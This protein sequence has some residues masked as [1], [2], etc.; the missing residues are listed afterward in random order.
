MSED[1]LTVQ[2][3]EPATCLDVPAL[4][5]TGKVDKSSGRQQG[6]FNTLS[7]SNVSST[8]TW[9]SAI[10]RQT[11]AALEQLQ[12]QWRT[13]P[14]FMPHSW[15]PGTSAVALPLSAIPLLKRQGT[16]PETL[17]RTAWPSKC[18]GHGLAELEWG[19][20][21]PRALHGA[22][23]R[24]LRSF[25][26]GRLCAEAALNRL[27]SS[28]TVIPGFCI[29][30]GVAEGIDMGPH[31][32]PVWPEVN[33]HCLTGSITHSERWAA[34]VVCPKAVIQSIGI[35]CE[36][37]MDGQS[38]DAALE[39]CFTKW[40]LARYPDLARDAALTT[41]MYAA[42][43][44]FYKAIWPYVRRFVD[45]TEVEVLGM[46]RPCG[47][48]HLQSKS[49]DVAMLLRQRWLHRFTLC[50]GTVHAVSALF[51]TKR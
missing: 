25:M 50:G 32:E 1:E 47:T 40:E 3:G 48:L 46:E 9:H 2:T 18:T 17:D 15:P 13:P 33:G 41:A 22:S 23:L 42:K 39:I 27:V 51:S 28:A 4:G 29:S 10:E 31:G 30:T 19:R 7:R 14:L 36:E 45:F 43:E 5:L 6:L 34:A 26:A 44:A 11:P 21:V 20:C 16:E 38:H 35:D 49:R 8:L 24:R 12:R 37:L